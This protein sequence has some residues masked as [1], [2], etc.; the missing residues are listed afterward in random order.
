MVVSWYPESHS[1]NHHAIVVVRE[2]VVTRD[3]EVLPVSGVAEMF[4]SSLSGAAS[5]PCKG[6]H[7]AVHPRDSISS[8]EFGRKLSL[9]S[10]PL[11]LFL[12]LVDSGGGLLNIMVGVDR[13]N[14]N[15]NPQIH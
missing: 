15:K 4:V 1:I 5:H 13:K 10:F 9:H 6:G 3:T 7:V 14:E 11:Q 12:P 2:D 8:K